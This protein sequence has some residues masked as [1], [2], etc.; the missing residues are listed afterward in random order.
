M[1]KQIM[2]LANK[3]NTKGN[4][5]KFKGGKLTTLTFFQIMLCALL[6]ETYALR[7]KRYIEIF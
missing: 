2:S 6:T 3:F 4:Q 7:L 5:F 1:R